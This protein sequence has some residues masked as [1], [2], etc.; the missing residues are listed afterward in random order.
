L[1][2]I[3]VKT[4]P[5]AGRR[6]ELDAEV[7]IGRQDGDLVLEDPEISRRHAVV[8]RSG[9][10]VVVEDLDSTNG[11]FVNGERIR[12]P[13]A[14]RPGD[15]V[16][17]GRTTLEIE[18][19][20]R[21]D[22]TIVSQ[23]DDRIDET[24]V[25]LPLP[26][27]QASSTPAR[28]SSEPRTDVEDATQP[29]PSREPRRDVEDATHPLPSRELEGG[30]RPT[31]SRRS[32]RVIGVGVVVLAVLLAAIAYVR[33]VDRPAES[34]FASSASDVCATVQR[35][36]EGVDLSGTPT[37]RQLLR[38]MNI[39]LQAFGAMRALEPPVQ[40]PE[41]SRFLAAFAKTNA[42]ITRLNRSIG[43]GKREVARARGTL[44]EDVRDERELASK[45][46]IGECGGLGIG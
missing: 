3:L 2:A 17:V 15:Q 9:A 11:T 10:S 35:S 37:S 40:D 29:L 43:S 12:S 1:T 18:P 32:R 24:I 19:D 21:S 25:S 38:A 36:V 31:R 23:P 7:A 8:R 13:K 20:P 16:R 30:V 5:K 44:R 22:D 14:V 4:G 27:D 26:P 6:V 39:R 46:G 42:S 34:D 28:P 45:A 33:L 41:L